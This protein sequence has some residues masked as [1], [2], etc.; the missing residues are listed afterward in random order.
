MH[1]GGGLVPGPVRDQNPGRG[2]GETRSQNQPEI[3][4]HQDVTNIV[5]IRFIIGFTAQNI[6]KRSLFCYSV[7]RG[8]SAT[9]A[10]N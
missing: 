5:K 3:N 7:S 6:F 9:K 1:C 8:F 10:L 4:V 2:R